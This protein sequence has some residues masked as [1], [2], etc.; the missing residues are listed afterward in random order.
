MVIPDQP[1]QPPLCSADDDKRVGGGR[2][3]YD[4]DD[5][6]AIM[7]R[8]ITKHE[9]P[10]VSLLPEEQRSALKSLAGKLTVVVDPHHIAPIKDE[11]NS[12]VCLRPWQMSLNDDSEE[13]TSFSKGILNY[14][15]QPGH[16]FVS[17]VRGT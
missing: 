2:G 5:M 14:T 16:E 7:S 11:G 8:I 17:V 1:Q 9:M 12:C 10:F 4:D 15:N 6:T 3:D 13:L